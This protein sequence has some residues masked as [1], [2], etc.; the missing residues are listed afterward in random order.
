MPAVTVPVHRPRWYLVPLRVL[1]ITIII[2]LLCFAVSLFLGIV[3]TALG[4]AV[5]GV[6]PNMALAYRRIAFPVAIVAAAG[7]LIT[8][9][10]ME[11]R[12]YRR[13][14]TLDRIEHELGHAS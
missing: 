7:G 4:A 13:A 6:H 14:R 9:L 8:S 11:I 2:T 3:G 10:V 1:V 12:Q 5:R